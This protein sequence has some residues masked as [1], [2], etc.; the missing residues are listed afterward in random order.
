MDNT[1]KYKLRLFSKRLSSGNYQVTFY[2]N[3][4]KYGHV[5]VSER[6]TL[7]EVVCRIHKALQ[8][9]SKGDLYYHGH[10]YSLNK[11][12]QRNHNLVIFNK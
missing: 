6:S 3:E 1:P 11:L 10:L 4:N 9:L 5:L 12:S 7:N 2:A 8:K